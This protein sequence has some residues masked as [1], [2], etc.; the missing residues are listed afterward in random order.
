MA[1]QPANHIQAILGHLN[2]NANDTCIY[3]NGP[4]LGRII[5]RPSNININQSTNMIILDGINQVQVQVHLPYGTVVR[6]PIDEENHIYNEYEI[7]NPVFNRDANQIINN[8]GRILFGEGV[9]YYSDNVVGTTNNNYIAY[10]EEM[11]PITLHVGTILKI[12]GTQ[13]RINLM[14]NTIA[15]I[16]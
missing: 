13:T 16:R 9:E 11:A 2:N 14:D 1:I 15:Y 6:L 10:I 5:G 12:S 7:I 3:F 8:T 4:N